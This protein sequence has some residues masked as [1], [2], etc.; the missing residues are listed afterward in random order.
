[1]RV[2]HDTCLV[3]AFD[4]NG[5]F[6]LADAVAVAAFSGFATDGSNIS[7]PLES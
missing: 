7:R 4:R 3:N 2:T 5:I 6:L 1:M